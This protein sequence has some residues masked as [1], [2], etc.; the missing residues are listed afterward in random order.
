MNTKPFKS[1]RQV[2]LAQQ[3]ARIGAG[4]VANASKPFRRDSEW[5]QPTRL[6]RLVDVLSPDFYVALGTAIGTICL[7]LLAIWV[8]L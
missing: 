1:D 3:W 5:P 8:G 2:A 4:R 7:G 6:Q